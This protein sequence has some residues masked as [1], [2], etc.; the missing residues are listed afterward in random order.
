M[1]RKPT[2]DAQAFHSVRDNL[3]REVGGFLKYIKSKEVPP[4]IY[5]AFL[6]MLF[7]VAESIGDLVYRRNSTIENLFMIL[8]EKYATICNIEYAKVAA[9]LILVYRHSMIH[10][11][12]L[13]EIDFDGVKISWGLTPNFL[14]TGHLKLTIQSNRRR[15]TKDYPGNTDEPDLIRIQFSVEQFYKDTLAVCDQMYNVSREFNGEAGKRY[16]S[17]KILHLQKNS[18]RKYDIEAIKEIADLIKR[19]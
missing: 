18:K 16:D 14:T 7:P 3:E 17:W 11:D 6:R 13:R 10:T 19:K 2:T 9:L 8:K 12:A 5:W 1:E 15:V 4:P